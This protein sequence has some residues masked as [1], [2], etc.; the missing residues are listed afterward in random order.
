MSTNKRINNIG[1]VWG[2][3]TGLGVTL[4]YIFMF[5]G[6]LFIPGTNNFANTADNWLF[7]ISPEAFGAVGAMINFAVAHIVSKVT[8]EPPEEIKHMVEHIRIPKGAGAA[9]EH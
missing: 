8:H 5:K 7:G 6:W 2:M 9:T 1:A 3:L 4:V